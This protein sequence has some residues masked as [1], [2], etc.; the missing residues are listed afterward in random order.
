MAPVLA[1][2]VRLAP[3]AHS[4]EIG[5]AT[6]TSAQGGGDGAELT[7]WVRW[8]QPSALSVTVVVFLTDAL[9]PALYAMWSRTRAMPAVALSVHVTEALDHGPVSGDGAWALMRMST[10][11][12]GNGWTV[13][14]DCAIWDV[15]GRPLA[16]ARQTRPVRDAA[17]S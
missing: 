8:K 13:D 7:A 1:P 3:F 2:P 16:Q 10:A 14:D 17:G 12:A 5:P 15:D 9:P 4:P 6:P 11:F